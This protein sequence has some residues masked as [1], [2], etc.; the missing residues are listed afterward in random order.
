MIDWLV[1]LIFSWGKLRD[2]VT[3]EVRM[4]DSIYRVMAQDVDQHPTNLSWLENGIWKGWSYS[5]EYNRYYFDDFGSDNLSDLW[6][7]LW[8]RE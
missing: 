3:F 8:N 1:N 7:E 4:Y 6:K 5:P 2:A